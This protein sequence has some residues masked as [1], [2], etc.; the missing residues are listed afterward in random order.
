MKMLITF[1][2]RIEGVT[3]LDDVTLEVDVPENEDGLPSDD[4]IASQ[5][6]EALWERVTEGD[7]LGI[8]LPDRFIEE[9]KVLRE[10][11]LSNED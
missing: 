9:Y 7:L 2:L 11:H 8:G 1:T 4:E 5:L 10:E 6:S 3:E